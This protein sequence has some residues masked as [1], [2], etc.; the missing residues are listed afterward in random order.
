MRKMMTEGLSGAALDW[1]VAKCE[2][3]MDGTNDEIR[4]LMR[5]Y[6]PSI[7][8]SDGGPI[9]ERECINIGA[10]K[11]PSD[12]S[13][14]RWGAYIYRFSTHMGNDDS[15]ITNLHGQT[16]LIAAM[17]C[18]VF[19]HFGPEILIPEEYIDENAN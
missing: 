5:V 7:D 14:S 18:Y 19:T 6:R 3:L 13:R 8:W 2:A 9:I 1:A 10:R 17:R 11:Q 12:P 15:S 16:P 4:G